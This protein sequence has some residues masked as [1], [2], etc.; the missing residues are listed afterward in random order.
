MVGL[1]R[2]GYITTALKQ[3]HFIQRKNAMRQT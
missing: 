2:K 3:I 1:H